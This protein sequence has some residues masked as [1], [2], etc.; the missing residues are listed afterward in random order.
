MNATATPTAR[1]V[2]VQHNALNTSIYRVTPLADG[3]EQVEYIAHITQADEETRRLIVEARGTATATGSTSATYREEGPGGVVRAELTWFRAG[4]APRFTP[5]V[6]R[7]RLTATDE[8]RALAAEITAQRDRTPAKGDRYVVAELS[9]YQLVQ[10]RPLDHRSCHC[11]DGVT[12]Y[13]VGTVEAVTY[14]ADNSIDVVVRCEDGKV[15]T[16]QT[17][18][19]HGDACF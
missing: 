10:N 19:P 4:S 1:L 18:A 17:V 9:G 2:A 11:G 6:H 3:M 15:R 8:D 12:T 13:H 5:G 16:A 14:W 7:A